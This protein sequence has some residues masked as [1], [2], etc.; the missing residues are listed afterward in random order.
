MSHE[1]RKR[2]RRGS[3][4]KNSTPATKQDYSDNKGQTAVTTSDV[5][6]QN[7]DTYPNVDHRHRE[8]A[9]NESKIAAHKHFVHNVKT[10]SFDT[11]VRLLFELFLVAA[12]TVYAVAAVKGCNAT[13]QQLRAYI[14][15]D[16]FVSAGFVAT[17][18]PPLK[19]NVVWFN[20]PTNSGRPADV[21][22]NELVYVIR[23]SSSAKNYGITP[24]QDVITVSAPALEDSLPEIYPCPIETIRNGVMY[25]P[26][27]TGYPEE[28]PTL[29]L[30]GDQFHAVME[31]STIL[32]LHTCTTYTDVFDRK[33]CTESC[34]QWNV[35][36]NQ[37]N[38]CVG[39]NGF[40][41]CQADYK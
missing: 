37:W 20:S 28:E 6:V 13:R 38:F 39:H 27:S 10:L 12:T 1:R 2:E 31:G 34:S 9:Q 22:P 11:Q 8:D 17:T 4:L 23:T 29:I 5:V 19:G 41:R 24:A 40:D 3:H 36:L 25:V 32:Y 30:R 33:W 21:K 16:S 14:A 15:R 26:N 18:E 35:K 7:K